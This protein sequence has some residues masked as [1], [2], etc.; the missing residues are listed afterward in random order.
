MSVVLAALVG[1]A[2]LL[3]VV[4][5]PGA[6]SESGADGAA[7]AAP[8]TDDDSAWYEQLKQLYDVRSDAFATRQVELLSEVYTAGSRQ[9]RVDLGTIES[10]RSQDRS[11]VGFAPTV[12][13]VLSVTH[14]TDSVVLVVRDEIAPFSIVDAG[15]TEMPVAGRASSEVVFR[16]EQEAGQWLI[17]QVSRQSE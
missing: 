14:E 10:L 12:R 2:V 16:L 6:D 8:V 1:L 5:W 17:A 9:L 15:G 4:L 13:E 3:G 7:D 11:V